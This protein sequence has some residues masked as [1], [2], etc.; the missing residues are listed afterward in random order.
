MKLCKILSDTPPQDQLQNKYSQIK[1]K[2][3]FKKRE[4]TQ[5]EILSNF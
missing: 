5:E 3:M 1:S 4:Q 2:Y